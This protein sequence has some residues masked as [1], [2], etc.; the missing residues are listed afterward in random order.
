VRLQLL[1]KREARGARRGVHAGKPGV[2]GVWFVHVGARD[3]TSP[4]G[5]IEAGKVDLVH[6]A[7]LF[8]VAAYRPDI[9][10]VER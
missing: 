2:K 3:F 6:R 4:F 9:E 7:L 8:V 1:T 10:I 5:K